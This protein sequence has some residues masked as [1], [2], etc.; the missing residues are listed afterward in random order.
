MRLNAFRVSEPGV[1]QKGNLM[2][3]EVSFIFPILVFR[4][5]GTSFIVIH[6]RFFFL[7]FPSN[8]HSWG[9][10]E[11]FSLK[12]KLNIGILLMYLLVS[13]LS[14]PF[15]HW[16]PLLLGRPSNVLSHKATRSR[17]WWC[18]AALCRLLL[19]LL[20]C[21]Q[22]GH[23]RLKSLGLSLPQGVPLPARISLARSAS[24]AERCQE[25]GSQAGRKGCSPRRTAGP[26]LLS[27]SLPPHAQTRFRVP[28]PV[29]RQP[30]DLD[31]PRQHQQEK[32]V[33]GRCGLCAPS[34]QTA[35]ATLPSS[36]SAP[37]SFLSKPGLPAA[38]LYSVR[39][40]L[41]RN[42]LCSNANYLL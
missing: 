10:G 18:F 23:P 20:L 13:F 32:R 26:S 11:I 1:F 19:F 39:K 21:S 42:G 4:D 31:L 37:M 27:L 9:G 17:S 35:P 6:I 38:A 34:V 2:R 7:P 14:L 12:I 22:V 15:L 16:L 36:D 33:A 3:I 30:P 28:A 8:F 25:Q 40:D 29:V 41:N 24:P 5:W